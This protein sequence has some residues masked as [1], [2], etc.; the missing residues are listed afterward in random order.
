MVLTRSHGVLTLRLDLPASAH[1]TDHNGRPGDTDHNGRPGLLNGS[2]TSEWTLADT[3]PL[4]ATI[5]FGAGFEHLA[6]EDAQPLPS[7]IDLYYGPYVS[8]G[9]RVSF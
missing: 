4:R 5:L 3:R 8:L 1:D 2:L 9:L 6:Y 7:R